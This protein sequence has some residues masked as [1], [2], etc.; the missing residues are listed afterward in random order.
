M[1]RPIIDKMWEIWEITADAKRNLLKISVAYV[2]FFFLGSN[3][4]KFFF[5]SRNQLTVLSAE[6][7][8][9]GRNIFTRAIPIWS[10][11]CCAFPLSNW[12]INCYNWLWQISSSRRLKLCAEI[13]AQRFELLSESVWQK[14]ENFESKNML[15]YSTIIIS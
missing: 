10:S 2:I 3:L 14:P 12:S 8:D 9:R 7:W 15:L 5:V 11:R 13:V 6:I 1:R 4:F